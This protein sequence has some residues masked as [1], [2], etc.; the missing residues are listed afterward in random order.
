MEKTVIK[1]N[2][3]RVDYDKNRITTA[4]KKA[5]LASSDKEYAAIAEKLSSDMETELA[6]KYPDGVYHVEDIQDIA[7]KALMSHGLYAAAKA[8][9][10]YRAVH[11]NIRNV[12]SAQEFCEQTITGYTGEPDA[13][14]FLDPGAEDVDSSAKKNWHVKQNASVSYSVGAMI[15]NNSERISKAHWLGKFYDKEIVD[16]YK[17]GAIHIH[18]LGMLTGYCF[19]GDTRIKT[20]DGK[21]PTL[22]ELA[23]NPDAEFAVL[24][25]DYQNNK[26]VH[27]KATAARKTRTVTELAKVFL[28]DGSVITST[29][30]HPF[31]KRDGNY[32]DAADLKPGM[33]LMTTHTA[34]AEVRK[35]DLVE[36]EPTDVYD[37]T[38]PVYHNFALDCGV[39]VHNCAG[40]DLKKLIAE[41]LGGV[42]GKISSGPAKHLSTLCNQM[43]NFL[44]IMQ[45][46]WAGAQ[47]FSSF[48][49]YLAPFLKKDHLSYDQV[50]QCIQSF[51]FGVNIPSRWGCVDT[52]TEVLSE[53]GFKRY[54][55]LKEGD[56]IFTWND[57]KL[58]LNTVNKVVT[59]PY[60]GFMHSYKGRG[61]HQFVT[62]TH[63]V[64]AKKNGE[65]EY[66]IFHSEEIFA[67][68]A[69]FALPI[70]FNDTALKP[71]DLT[72]AEIR[73]AAIVYTNGNFDMRQ[74]SVHKVSVFQSPSFPEKLAEIRK[75][76]EALNLKWTEKAVQGGFETAV[77]K[78][79]FYG[80]SARKLAE[81]TEGKT[82]IKGIFTKMDKRQSKLFLDT[83]MN[84]DGQPE[85]NLLQYDNEDIGDSLQ[86]IA[87][88]AGETSVKVVRKHSTYIRRRN[89]SEAIW[90][91]EKTEVPYDGV[92]WCPNVDNGTAVFRKDGCVFIS[93]QTQAPF[94]NITLDW[95]CPDD[96]KNLPAVVGG[97]E[98]NFTYGDCEDEMRIVNK[99]FIEVMVEGDCDGRGFAYPIPTYSITRNFD[100]SDT[101]NNRLLFEMAAK[102]GTP[103]F[104]NYVNSDMKPSD[105]RSMCPLSGSEHVLVRDDY[106][107]EWHLSSIENLYKGNKKEKTYDV[108]LN[109]KSKKAGLHRFDGLEFL[110]VKTINGYKVTMSANHQNLV[111][112]DGNTVVLPADQL[113]ESDYLP[114]NTSVYEGGR[115]LTYEDGLMVGAFLGD[116]SL[117]DDYTVCYSL[118]N[119]SKNEFKAKI[120][121]VAEDKFGAKISESAADSSGACVNVCITSRML[122]GLIEE[123][124]SGKA[125][126]KE[127]N[128]KCLGRSTAF[129]SGILEGYQR[130]DGGNKSRI[131][132]S[133]LKAVESVTVLLES[134]GMP[135]RVTKD[136]RK[137]VRFSERPNYCI[138]YYSPETN[139][140]S[141]GDVYIKKDG[142]MWFKIDSIKK[143]DT[144][145]SVGYCFEVLNDEKPY[146]M[147]PSGMVTHNCRLRLDL[148][149]LRKQNGGNFGAGENTGSIGV[150]TINM[151]RIA[152]LSKNED[153]FFERLAHM[154]DLSARSLDIKRHV[155]NKYMDMGLYPYTRRYLPQGFTNHFS[156][157][158]LVGMN[159]ACLNAKWIKEDMTHK[160]AYEWSGKVLDFMREKLKDYQEEYGNLFNL[161]ATPAESTAYRLAMHDR[162]LYPDIIT[163]GKP[164]ETPYYTNSSHLPV[165]STDDV[166]EALDIQDNLQTKYTS[167]TVFH[168][169]LSEKLPSWKSAMQLVK[170]VT[171]NYRLPYF[172]LSPVY[173]VCEEHGYL[174]GEQKVCP[175]CGKPTEIY[176]R[177]TGYYRPVSNWN[178]GKLQEYEDRKAYTAA[179]SYESAKKFSDSGRMEETAR[180]FGNKDVS[181]GT[182]SEDKDSAPRLLLF[183]TPTCPNCKMLKARGVLHGYT[184]INAA[185]KNNL[186]LVREFHVMSAPTLIVLKDGCAP[187]VYA[188][189][190]EIMGFVNR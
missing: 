2:G 4:L 8:F 174:K 95:T 48:D 26:I 126:D 136:D 164:G 87:L 152:Y 64:L 111:L 156:T 43:V 63:R 76:A 27:A 13:T 82:R 22:K 184:E 134:L 107:K 71:A 59:K 118:N 148:R 68:S 72:D 61:Y 6:G 7:E 120:I 166:F 52:E 182:S 135:V 38:V 155:I 133:S 170:T 51:V 188:N 74:K 67:S 161:E 140:D 101:E 145:G 33:L 98:Q 34:G 146:F 19:T 77:A 130:T 132:T 85:K 83:W 11:E 150:V 154:M 100:W 41:G 15:L 119:S 147:L 70:M 168:C 181:E 60:K 121:E 165:G 9:I 40:W 185:D 44:G 180:T 151:P 36:V 97:E 178:A 141:Y 50:K 5:I 32:A 17:S 86:L 49:T 81:L 66:R 42:K 57:G 176:S 115:G 56:R 20:L 92:V 31:M 69:K 21:N 3:R 18:D 189:A 173:S 23:E 108:L 124:V 90:N 62:P 14:E 143:A 109:G 127:L 28:E 104:S 139:Q 45:N 172:T 158:G 138:R 35:V 37:I 137:D 88:R 58:E 125:L 157:I 106:S 123:Y 102:Y 144:T 153:E 55:E 54:D 80:D 122:R 190:S 96:L 94:S 93:G 39:F 10:R 25:Y 179:G 175:Y 128:V 84:C 47:A 116:G 89:K 29:T 79:T 24:A 169:F 112:R 105:V 160:K 162:K 65:S 159:E 113:T 129:R 46:E 12:K 186:D 167:G 131:Y 78:L 163:A 75:L 171:D 1:R 177:I 103:Y 183:T 91:Y 117:K 53:E 149:E 99:A 73:M 187:E 110:T 30:D 142:Y 114:F 16:A